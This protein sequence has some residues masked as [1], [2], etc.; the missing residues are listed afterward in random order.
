LDD[1]S[2]LIVF[3]GF[4]LS[5]NLESFLDAFEKALA[6]RGLPRKLYVDNGAAYRSRQLEFTCASLAIALIHARPYKPQG[7]GKIERFFRTVRGDFLP[8]ARISNLENLNTS[9][10]T[11]LNDMYHQRKHSATGMTPFYRFTR[12][13]ACIRPAPK[14]LT[15]YFR[16]AVYRSVAK[17]RTVTLEGRLFEAPVL[18]VG[19]R[20][21]L[22]YHGRSPD[23]VEAF[24]NQTSHGYLTPVN[25]H[26][27]ARVKRDR[28]HNPQLESTPDK[29]YTGGDLWK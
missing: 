12:N 15:N 29:P 8:E 21:L 9:F 5:E 24:W 7:K 26:V 16:K 20:I 19:K 6:K 22:L 23:R 3:G 28:N 18:L 25:L 4:Y 11:W 10:T 2:R 13:L 27:N 1:H 17:D 14:D